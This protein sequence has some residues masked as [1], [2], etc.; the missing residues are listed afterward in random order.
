MNNTLY[1]AR[2]FRQS[3][4]SLRERLGIVPARTAAEQLGAGPD[5]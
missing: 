4:L 2:L 3:G 1:Y 5:L